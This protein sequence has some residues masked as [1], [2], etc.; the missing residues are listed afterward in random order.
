MVVVSVG[1]QFDWLLKPCRGRGGGNRG[2][3]VC[4][5]RDGV[6]VC[7]CVCAVVCLPIV[8]WNLVPVLTGR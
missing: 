8:S 5:E 3:G 2:T 1:S 4:V 6:C 7:V